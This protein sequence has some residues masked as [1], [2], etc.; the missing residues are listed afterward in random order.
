MQRLRAHRVPITWLA[1]LAM[2]LVALA[3]LIAK[4][5]RA[6]GAPAWAEICSAVGS[7]WV[8]TAGTAGEQNQKGPASGHALGHCP[9]CT[10]HGPDL[11]PAPSAPTVLPAE[12]SQFA[13]PRLF[14]LAPSTPFAWTAA[15]PRAPPAFS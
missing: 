1:C 12:R 15:Q 6:D 13:V 11:A 2:L 9:Y 5:A 14:L 10:V 4:A 8:D 3:P 7:R